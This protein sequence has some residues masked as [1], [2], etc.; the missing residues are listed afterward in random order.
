MTHGDEMLDVCKKEHEIYNQFMVT[1]YAV[2]DT[3]REHEIKLELML[4]ERKEWMDEWRKDRRDHFNSFI[5]ILAVIALQVCGFIY[6][7]GR[8]TQIVDVN[9]GRITAMEELHPR[10]QD[11]RQF[12]NKS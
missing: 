7:W 12:L 4:K 11:G 2:R 3:V 1:G 5:S 10:T 9:S 8:L 6:M